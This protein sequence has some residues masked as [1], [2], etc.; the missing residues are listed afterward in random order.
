VLLEN[1]EIGRRTEIWDAGRGADLAVYAGELD[2]RGVSEMFFES[3]PFGN[4]M[5]AKGRGKLVKK[6]NFIV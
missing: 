6:D 4:E 1:G 5:G 3:S 2:F